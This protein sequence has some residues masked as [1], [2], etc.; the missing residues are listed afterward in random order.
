MNRDLQNQRQ[1]KLKKEIG[2]ERKGVQIN[3]AQ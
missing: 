3:K 2:K 1:Q